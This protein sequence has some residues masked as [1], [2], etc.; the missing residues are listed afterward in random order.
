MLAAV[1]DRMSNS[2]LSPADAVLFVLLGMVDAIDASG[3]RL[4]LGGREARVP[5][6]VALDGVS[7]GLRLVV[8][9]RLESATGEATI[10]GLIS[11]GAVAP[12]ETTRPPSEGSTLVPLIVSLLMELASEIDVLDC[13]LLP[14]DNQYAV[15]MA[16][17]GGLDKQVFLPR[18]VLERANVDAVARRRTRLLLSAAVRALRGRRAIWASRLAV[19]SASSE[20]FTGPGEEHRCE[21]CEAVLTPNEPVVVD[22]GSSHHLACSLSD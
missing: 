11:I 20:R 18:G 16:I 6:Y 17:L 13:H 21:R 9:G 12:C 7:P 2:S 15:R 8:A 19:P 3:R 22:A 5:P 10:V 14:A 1:R 4:C